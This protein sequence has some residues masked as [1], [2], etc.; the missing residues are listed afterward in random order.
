MVISLAYFLILLVRFF[1]VWRR[2]EIGRRPIQASAF[3]G[4][5]GLGAFGK[6]WND[7]RRCAIG[8]RETLGS[9][10]GRHAL[11]RHVGLFGIVAGGLG[12]ARGKQPRGRGE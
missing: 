1:L 10:Q 5:S 9:T 2:G 11:R 6:R 4:R 8:R 7:K 3:A 12:R